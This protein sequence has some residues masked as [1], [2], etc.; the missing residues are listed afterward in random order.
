MAPTLVLM[1]STY[2]PVKPGLHR[3]RG[4]SGDSGHGISGGFTP[5]P[6]P[7]ENSVTAAAENALIRV[8]RQCAKMRTWAKDNPNRTH[9]T[10]HNPRL[11][12]IPRLFRGH[13]GRL[14][15]VVLAAMALAGSVAGATRLIG[16]EYAGRLR[17][18][19]AELAATAERLR[20]AN[21]GPF[22][23]VQDSQVL[24]GQMRSLI[25]QYEQM[26]VFADSPYP[27]EVY[28][29]TTNAGDSRWLDLLPT[30]R[31]SGYYKE[32][33]VRRTGTRANYL[34][35]NDIEI[36][37]N[38]RH[39]SVTETFNVNGRV[40]LYAGGVF[41][42]ALPKPMR[43]DR[44]RIRID[45]ESTG[46][47]VYGVPYEGIVDDP[48]APVREYPGEV[49]L[50]TTPGGDSTWLETLCGGAAYPP[51]RQ[52]RLRRTG[53]AASYIRVRE[54]EVTYLGLRGTETVMLNTQGRDKLYFND[55]YSVA[56]PQPMRVVRVRIH[57]DHKSTG[58][59]VYGVY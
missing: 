57:I 12:G 44:M 40:K 11:G 19:S 15:A 23:Q 54:I 34:R 32:I 49:L 52:L 16:Q 2:R 58:L 47:E 1:M 27:G 41:Q 10:T 29:G 55:V 35:I 46:L 17:S 43:I 4:T 14:A 36:V 18:L 25:D 33:R 8:E 6:V 38:T 20:A 21:A 22:L 13:P 51:V 59:E 50:G 45:H 7:W 48:R 30:G 53:Q 3:I 31:Y 26:L 39:G 5:G 24:L 9:P 37:Q 42:L 28:I 56:L